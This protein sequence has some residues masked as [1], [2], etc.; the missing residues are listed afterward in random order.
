MTTV[1]MRADASSAVAFLTSTPRWAPSP[2]PTMMAVGVASPRASGQVMT[3]TV[4]ANSRAVSTP[5]PR[6]QPRAEGEQATD[7]RD[8]HQPERGAVGQ[9]L[10][11]ALEFWA[12]CTS[13]TICASAVSEPTLVARTPATVVLIDAP[14]TAEPVLFATGRLSPV[15]IDSSTSRAPSSTIRPRAPSR[16]VG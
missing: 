8:E 12:C 5:A 14:I 13:A 11:R 9:A 1:S 16:R 6:P 7:E 15:T 3:T 2:V 4:M 10:P